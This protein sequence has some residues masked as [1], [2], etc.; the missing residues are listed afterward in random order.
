MALPETVT[1]TGSSESLNAGWTKYNTLVGSVLAGDGT[2]R[3]LRV[4]S[5][6]IEDGTN[7]STIKATASNV[8]NGDA[9]AAE[10]NLGKS[11]DTGNFNLNAAGSAVHIESGAL[12]G[13]CTHVLMALIYDNTSDV[14]LLVNPTV[15]SNG[16]TLTYKRADT[17]AAADLTAILD[18]SPG[19]I[20]TQIIYLTDE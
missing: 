13:S 5:L 15:V 2:S 14:G 8:F 16:I 18:P 7:A 1:L 11:G 20:Y 17:G 4:M 12:T 19:I 3:A 10:D 9:I 6:K